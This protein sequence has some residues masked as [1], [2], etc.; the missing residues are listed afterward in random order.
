MLYHPTQHNTNKLCITLELFFYFFLH[1]SGTGKLH[2]LREMLCEQKAYV[3]VY[4][5]NVRPKEVLKY[6]KAHKLCIAL[7]D[8]DLKSADQII[9]PKS[10]VIIE[11]IIDFR[12]SDE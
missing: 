8:T 4:L 12:G 2:L 6:Q 3:K 7:K 5:I 9:T 1:R 10:I 11:D